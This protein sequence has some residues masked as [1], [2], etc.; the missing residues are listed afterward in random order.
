MEVEYWRNQYQR[1]N[2]ERFFAANAIA[3]LTHTV[4]QPLD[5][6]KTRAQVLQ[7]GKTFNGFAWQKGIYGTNIIRETLAAGGGYKKFYSSWDAF[8]LRTI[9]YTTLRVSSFLY[10]YDW[11]NPD[12]RRQARMDFYVYAGLLGGI[13]GGILTNPFEIVFTRMQADELYPEQC[14]RNYK[15]FADGFMKVAEEGALFRGAGANGLKFVGLVAAAT[16]IYDS[17]RE[18]VYFF[19]GPM[20]VT[21]I[22]ATLAGTLVAFAASMPFDTVR[23]R[24]HTMRPLPNGK[25][26]YS[27]SADCFAKI[28]KYE[29]DPSKLSNYGSF[30]SGGQ[31]YLLRLLGIALVS[32]YALDIYFDMNKLPELWQPAKYYVHGGIDYDIHNPYTQAFDQLM[33]RQF[34]MPIGMDST[35]PNQKELLKGL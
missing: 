14:R 3:L 31:M 8:F 29:C 12:P 15:N 22:T 17:I 9:A 2:K 23:T 28:C 26:P 21:R 10:F 19:F 24:M 6:A 1:M 25:Y 27:N 11:I 30:Y 33:M 32:Q 5:M 13:T 7:E 16:G 35:S 20:S 18:N 34:M 4:T